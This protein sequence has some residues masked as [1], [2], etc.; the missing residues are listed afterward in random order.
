MSGLV[1]QYSGKDVA[2]FFGHGG[3]DIQ[4]GDGSKAGAADG[5]DQDSRLLQ[6]GDDRRWTQAVA[7]HIEDD[8]VRIDI[9]RID[10]DRRDLLQ[11]SRQAL[12]VVMV[13]FQSS[14]MVFERI[15]AGCGEDAGLPHR[16]AI[17][18]AQPLSLIEEGQIIH[19]E[20]R[21]GRCSQ[22]LRETD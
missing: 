13:H 4:V 11:L 22:P 17:H 1:H 8:N 15:D 7:D 2:G 5:I 12:G 19:H 21:S 6:G 20:E 9:L 18:T 3:G 16:T 14:D 10:P